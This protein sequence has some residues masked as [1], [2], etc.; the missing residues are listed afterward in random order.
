MEFIKDS[1]KGR[2]TE[3]KYLNHT[4]RRLISSKKAGEK[5]IGLEL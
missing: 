2:M 1:L 4:K 3:S 5:M